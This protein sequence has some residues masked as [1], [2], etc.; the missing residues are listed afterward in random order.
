MHDF[1]ALLPALLERF[2]RCI[3]RARLVVGDAPGL[4]VAVIGDRAE[5][6]GDR[7]R[8]RSFGS[9]Y[10]KGEKKNENPSHGRYIVAP[11][12]QGANSSSP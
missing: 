4:R 11:S 5:A 7:G 9:K 2:D 1:A 12:T 6:V 10:P 3:A 8:F